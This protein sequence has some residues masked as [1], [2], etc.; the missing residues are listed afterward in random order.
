MWQDTYDILPASTV[1]D[2]V[3]VG[4]SSD[5]SNFSIGQDCVLAGGNR[6]HWGTSYDLSAGIFTAGSTPLLSNVI[7]SI[8]DTK[9]F[10]RISNPTQIAV[11]PITG[12]PILD[13]DGNFLN[14]DGNKTFTLPTSP[15]DG[16]GTATAT[17]DPTKIIAYVGPDWATAYTAGPV[18]VTRISGNTITLEN[19][20]SFSLQDKVFVTY[21][22]NLIIDDTWTIT[23]ELPGGVG[24][25]RYSVASKV[26]GTAL[27]ATLAPGGTISPVYAGSGAFNAQVSPL[28][29]GVE[30]VTITFDGVGGFTV[31]STGLTLT[32]SDL[33]FNHNKGSLGKTY[34]DPI[35][36]FRVTFDNVVFAP[37]YGQTT[38]YYVGRPTEPLISQT[39]F[40]A[41]ASVTIAVPGILLTIASTDGITQDNTDDT[42][43]LQTFNKSGN[44][45]ATGDSY[46]VTFD[47]AKTDYS[48]GYFTAMRDVFAVYGPLDITNKV[49]IGANL[50]FLNGARAVAIKQILKASGQTDAS[51]D[52]Y[53]AGIDE[54]DSPL[55][56]G[57]RPSF[58]QPMT[59][60]PDV[61]AYLASSNAV[62]SS[63]KYRN[64]RTSVIG[65]PFGTTPSAAI[66]QC[67]AIASE[68]ITAIYPEAAVVSIPDAFGN[69]VQ[70]LVDGAFLAVAV[71][72]FGCFPNGRYSYPINQ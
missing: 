32:G 46:Y 53:V 65:F 5:T 58:I 48:V 54:F 61:Q 68:K 71:S 33:T 7:A 31:T 27:N 36:G 35:T 2:L 19:S 24:V 69:S 37:T 63:I 64:E 52:A 30:T 38:L 66:T 26:N 17:E 50:A 55:P 41:N 18:D 23:N 20:P 49:V 62:Q 3:Q 11:N 40:F 43:L 12:D 59:T 22:E 1:I 28:T 10:G 16:T 25:G 60:N 13:V 72:R 29:A 42:V 15:V 14:T 47:K 57:Q 70:Y 8:T 6:L 56:N 4:L 45:P 21:F 51:F 39:W 44:E 34:I 67:K 9:V